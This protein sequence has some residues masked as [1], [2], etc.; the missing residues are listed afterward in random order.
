MVYCRWASHLC[1]TLMLASQLKSLQGQHEPIIVGESEE[2]TRYYIE[3][4]PPYMERNMEGIRRHTVDGFDC[5]F[6]RPY[7]SPA[8]SEAAWHGECHLTIYTVDDM[9]GAKQ[10]STSGYRLFGTAKSIE[11]GYERETWLPADH[12]RVC[13]VRRL[14]KTK[15]VFVTENAAKPEPSGMYYGFNEAGFRAKIEFD[16]TS[17]VKHVK[18]N[19]KGIRRVELHHG[20]DGAGISLILEPIDPK[21][22]DGSRESFSRARINTIEGWHVERGQLLDA[23]GLASFDLFKAAS[24]RISRAFRSIRNAASRFRRKGKDGLKDRLLT[25]G[26]TEGDNSDDQEGAPYMPDE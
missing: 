23:L 6:M 7:L 9:R 12:P 19:I 8:R 4:W 14:L 25:K 10:C 22:F 20:T 11:S 5:Y 1:F 18:V 2:G 21:T 24:C 17:Q 13:D 16:A 15:R 3:P 26:D